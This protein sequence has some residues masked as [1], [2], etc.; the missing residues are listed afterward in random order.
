MANSTDTFWSVNGVPIQT[1][2]YNVTTWGGDLQAPPPLR[3]DD[4]TVPYVPGRI[5][6]PRV[7]DS[8]TMTFSMWVIGADSD[9]RA[10]ASATSR[11]EFEKNLKM[12]RNLFWN[13]GQP[14]TLTK[15]WRE[16][17]SSTVLTAS[18]TAI[19]SGGFVPTMTGATRATFT[20]EMFLADPFFYGENETINFGATATATVSPVIKGDYETTRMQ[21]TFN[22]ARNNM[23]ITN[24]SRGIYVNVGQSVAAA[25]TIVVN[26]EAW[27][28]VRSNDSANLV[29]AVTYFGHTNWMSLAPGT[30]NLTL[31]STSGTASATIVYAPRYL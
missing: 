22:G 27:T 14:V 5:L 28:A 21:I 31:S 10:P 1:F 23:R 4:I 25:A 15:R 29:P 16:Y 17:G 24:T 11:A 6:M 8:R 18:A 7:P 2:G 19:F 20:A 3:G 30:Q 26:P 9:G 13:Q 12:L